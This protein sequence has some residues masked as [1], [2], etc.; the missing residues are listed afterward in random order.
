MKPRNCPVN[1]YVLSIILIFLMAAGVSAQV[2]SVRL[3]RK[4]LESYWT[5]TRDMVTAPVRW[6]GR[7]W[8]GLAAFSGT[9]FALTALDEPVRDYMQKH[10]DPAL[11]RISRYGLEPFGN[12][13]SF[14]TI[15]GF[16][17]HGL[18]TG[19]DRSRSTALMAAESYVLSGLLVRISKILAGRSR[20]D[21]PWNPGP[22]EWE[23]PFNGKSFP[24]GHTT[25]AFAV[26]S[27][28]AWQYR[29]TKWVPAAAWTV[30]SAVAMSRMYDNKHWLSDA[31]AGAVIGAATG[32]FICRQHDNSRLL[33]SPGF[34]AGNSGMKIVLRW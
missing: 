30:A 12:L 23:G 18:W 4:Y 6:K 20:P 29:E 32:R 7:Q 13:Y 22:D 26:A 33:I 27:V 8:L 2:D 9:T 14:G 16:L 5:D 19:N 31:F 1:K 10:Q 11:A 34:S 15:A 25:S 24:S 21:A 3:N 17:V 28:I